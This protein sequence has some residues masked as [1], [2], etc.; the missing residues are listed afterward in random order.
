[1]DM[2]IYFLHKKPQGNSAPLKPSPIAKL[3]SLTIIH[4]AG[5][6]TQPAPVVGGWMDLVQEAMVRCI[7]WREKATVNS[8]Q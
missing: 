1:L 7:E 5:W 3:S 8:L 4:K 2:Y 6:W